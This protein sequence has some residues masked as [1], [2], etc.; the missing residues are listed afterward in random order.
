MGHYQ[1]TL[2]ANYFLNDQVHVIF[3]AVYWVLVTLGPRECNMKII[4]VPSHSKHC[5][6]SNE[7]VAR[8]VFKLQ[9]KRNYFFKKKMYLNPINFP[10]ISA[11]KINSRKTKR[12]DAQRSAVRVVTYGSFANETTFELPLFFFSHP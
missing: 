3:T 11:R 1:P 7:A 9:Y 2:K 10:Q 8:Y 6:A 5:S 12:F 4:S